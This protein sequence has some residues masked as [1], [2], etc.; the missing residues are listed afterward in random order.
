MKE[1]DVAITPSID[2]HYF[3][4]GKVYHGTVTGDGGLYNVP[5][6]FG[7]LRIVMDNWGERSSHLMPIDFD[8]K[9]LK[10]LEEYDRLCWK[11]AGHWIKVEE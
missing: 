4:K 7:H 8:H 6:D 3:T 5:D 9:D 11:N 10:S 1:Y 2:S